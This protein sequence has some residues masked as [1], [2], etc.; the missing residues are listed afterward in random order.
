VV[1]LVIRSRSAI[2]PPAAALET[3][4]GYWLRLVSNEVSGAFAR[5]LQERQISVAEWVAMNQLETRAGL[6]AAKL[7][8]A[9]GMTRG[10]VSKVLEKLATKKLVSRTTSPVDSRVQQLSRTGPTNSA[11]P[12]RNCEQQR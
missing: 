1:E 2:D 7:A 4:T 3:H 12:H 10:A 5:T 6:T 11:K 9:M 8:A